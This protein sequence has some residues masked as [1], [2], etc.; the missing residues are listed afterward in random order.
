[1][2]TD[3]PRDAGQRPRSAVP[4]LPDDAGD[5]DQAATS[6]PTRRCAGAPAAATTRS[7]PPCRASC[8]SSA[9]SARTS[10]SSRASAARRASR[11][12]STP[13]ACTRSTAARR[14]SPP[15]LATSRAGPLGVGRHRR[16][17]RAVDRRQPPHPRAAPQRQ[18]DDPAVQQPDLRA[19][20][21]PVLPHLQGRAGHQVDARRLGRQPVQPGVAGARRRGHLRR[22]D[23]GLRPQAPHRASCGRRPS[24]AAPRSSRSTRTARSSTTAP[25]TCSRTAPS[26]RPA[27]C[28]CAHGEPVTVGAEGERKVLVRTTAAATS[29][30]PRPMP[31]GRDVVVHDAA[32]RRPVAG[33]RAL[34]PRHPRHDA[35]ADGRLPPGRRGR[36]TTTSSAPRSRRPSTAPAARRPTPT[37]PTCCAAATPGPSGDLDGRPT[38][39]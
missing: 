35:R 11:T 32:R 18:P 15:G 12:T 27:S 33:L 30:S 2:T 25:S 5:A 21:G 20:Q 26:R 34:A 28:T 4:H 23:D 8:P 16:R 1:M 17:R 24:T 19:D 37:S 13:T 31:R 29:S 38:G 3:R 10:S 22:A 9:C 6:P 36:P 39:A 14:R 7:S